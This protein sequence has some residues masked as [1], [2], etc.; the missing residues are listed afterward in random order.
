MTKRN[1]LKKEAE[2]VSKSKG[3][4]KWMFIPLLIVGSII[5]YFTLFHETVLQQTATKTESPATF[6]GSENCQSCHQAQ[7]DKWQHSHHAKAIELA[8][9]SN[10]LGDFS[11]VKFT[12]N[13]I[14]SHIYTRDNNYF[15]S[16]DDQ[17]GKISEFKIKYTFGVY[18]LQ[19]YLVEFPGGRMQ[20]LPFAWDSRTKE[21]GGQQWF[22]MYP[23]ERIDFK[24]Q[25]HWTKRYQNW[26]MM[27]AEC[28]STALRKNFNP[29]TNSYA[30]TWKELSVGC[31]SCHGPASNHMAW[32]T[33]DQN[34]KYNDVHK[35][36]SFTLQTNW[37]TSWQF[38][39]DSS[40][41]AKRV[42]L[43]SNKVAE[44]VCAACHARSS[45]MSDGWNS[46]PGDEFMQHH[47][48]ALLIEPLF[49]STGQQR[50]EVYVWN[51][52]QASKMYNKGVVCQD[53]HDP[54]TSKLLV[55][56]N[57]LCLRCHNPKVFEAPKHSFHTMGGEGSK[58]VNCHMSS[59][60]YMVVDDRRD[61]SF[62]IPRPDISE[63]TGSPN[64][65]IS[66]HTNK[67]NVWAQ[68]AMDKWYGKQW[69][70]RP[71]WA[72]DFHEASN[73]N[74]A[75]SKSLMKFATNN[76][77]PDI[78]RASSLTLITRSVRP[79]VIDIA[80]ILMHDSSAM[81]RSEAIKLVEGLNENDR[82]RLV[83][84]M[85][86]D[87]VKMVRVEAANVLAGTSSEIMKGT[88]AQRF[89][90]AISEYEQSLMLN[91][92]FPANASQLGILYL[93][94]ARYDEAKRWL[95]FS[96]QLDSQF[97]AGYLNLADL[98]RTVNDD[99]KA[100][101]TLH[102]GLNVLPEGANL[103]YS[104]G[105]ANVRV[106]N[107]DEAIKNIQEAIRLSPENNQF[108]YVY[109]IALHDKIS[110]QRGITVLKQALS[111]QPNNADLLQ[112]MVQ[113]QL[114]VRNVQ[115]AKIYMKQYESIYP[116]DAIVQQWS[117]MLQ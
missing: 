53:C 25:L 6:V 65:C 68:S 30:T 56:D 34:D 49:W 114:E 27:C 14:E 10:V 19:Q 20:A 78:V 36:F 12:Y 112:L 32:S 117:Q 97:E 60:K 62:Q 47:R 28:H 107:V 95:T 108:A 18:P 85:L 76:S 8:S 77:L 73:G 103:H 75:A 46:S 50:D 1:K 45:Q 69:R 31:E 63:A 33:K 102:V 35:G 40:A 38:E 100:I 88:D 41:I 96:I 2:V 83:S 92:D 7:H 11:D 67:N 93:R 24:D 80:Q 70:N 71:T 57:A 21:E 81:V 13:D 86:S 101:E 109:A 29:Q 105:L 74:S 55:M 37:A 106:G 115:E 48:P 5:I 42:S 110:P 89:N 82:W 26:N 72:I 3:N 16:T 66:C 111:R 43:Q 116:N 104:L 44:S 17:N 84:P 61:H 59:T 113:W 51:T 4:L 23:Q 99:Q 94:L 58:C 22:H 91:S 15:V 64:A 9:E 98:Y 54:H 52:F 90:R 87:P 79:E 39:N